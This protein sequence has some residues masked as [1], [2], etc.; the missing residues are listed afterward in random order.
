MSQKERKDRKIKDWTEQNRTEHRTG[1]NRTGIGQDRTRLNM[2][3]L[4]GH[5]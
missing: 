5:S 2:I 3:G 1:Q 4:N